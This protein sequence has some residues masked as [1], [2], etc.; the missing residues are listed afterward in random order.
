MAIDFA[1]ADR[2]YQAQRQ[3]QGFHRFP[4]ALF[5][6]I[7][8]VRYSPRHQQHQ[9]TEQGKARH[10]STGRAGCS[11]SQSSRLV[12]ARPTRVSSPIISGVSRRQLPSHRGPPPGQQGFGA[13]QHVISA[14]LP[15]PLFIG[16]ARCSVLCGL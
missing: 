16:F 8:M 13:R 10:V 15:Q 2:S 12:V 14:G 11:S 9:Q 3:H 1:D 7:D 5:H 4:E 6:L